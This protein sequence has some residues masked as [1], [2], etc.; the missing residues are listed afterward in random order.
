MSLWDIVR[1]RRSTINPVLD[2]SALAGKTNHE[3]VYG[4][5]ARSAWHWRLFAFLMVG[6]VMWDRIELAFVVNEKRYI[7][8]VMAEHEDGSMRFIGT[9]DPNWKPTDRHIVDELRSPS[10]VV[11]TL[12]GR[13]KDAQFDK[14]LWQRLYNRA[15]VNGRNQLGAAYAE[16]E[17]VPEKGRIDIEVVSINKLSDQTFDVRWQEKRHEMDGPVKKTLR[18]RGLFQVVIEVPSKD[19]GLLAMNEKGVWIEGW[20]IA[21]E[22]H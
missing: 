12:R 20:S 6:V 8:V 18:F 14:K 16:L 19:V 9:P 5:Y 22:E 2:T 21:P 4:S 7:P 13:T 11:Q 10:G 15:T 17:A 3:T 1:D